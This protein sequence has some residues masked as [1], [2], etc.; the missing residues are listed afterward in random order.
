MADIDYDGF[1]AGQPRVMTAPGKG[2]GSPIFKV[3]NWLG[4]VTS[5]AM[6]A[7]LGYWGYN[8]MM[9]DVTGVPV[10]RA[11]EGP[12]REAPEDPG[13]TLAL[14]QGLSVNEVTGTGTAGDL[15]R[16]ILLAPDAMDL[17]DEDLPVASLAEIAPVEPAAPEAGIGSVAVEDLPEDALATDVAVAEALS[18]TPDPDPDPDPEA[19]AR[20]LADALTEGVAPLSS[21]PDVERAEVLETPS[22]PE[23]AP[24]ALHGLISSPR[25]PVRPAGLGKGIEIA[26]AAA[27]VEP[28]T[29]E[30]LSANAL[31]IP[32]DA[33]PAGTR[34][35]QLGAFD[36]PAVARDQWDKISTR[37][38]EYFEGK[39]RVV[40]E[41]ESGGKTFFRLRA[42]GFADL[43]DARHFCTALLAGQTDCIPVVVK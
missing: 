36:S 21:A 34:L 43:S 7:G 35:V 28:D 40:Q 5:L 12:F 33:I 38:E 23:V 2:A 27:G 25:P 15:P 8:L 3:I 19:Q 9:R 32:V 1:E 14:H 20:A 29:V 39:R 37:F 30:A 26:S 10:V 17:E 11:L 31:E 4:G 18:L 42:E 6:I 24:E 13:G 41:A 22:L 16:A